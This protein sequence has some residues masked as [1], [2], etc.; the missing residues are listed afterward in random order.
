MIDAEIN[1]SSHNHRTGISH[2]DGSPPEDLQPGIVMLF[3]NPRFGPDGGAIGST[4]PRPVGCKKRDCPESGEAQAGHQG[5]RPHRFEVLLNGSG[6]EEPRQ[7]QGFQY[8]VTTW[9]QRSASICRGFQN[10]LVHSLGQRST[11]TLV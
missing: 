11:T 6:Y 4:P 3:D 2:G 8:S 9:T 5:W 7:P 1:I 10:F